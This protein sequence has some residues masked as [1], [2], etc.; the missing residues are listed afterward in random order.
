MLTPRGLSNPL[1]FVVGTLPEGNEPEE[2]N[3]DLPTYLGWVMP[4]DEPLGQQFWAHHNSAA[5]YAIA[6]GGSL[7]VVTANAATCIVYLLCEW[8]D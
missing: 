2:W 7:R 1:R 4:L 5:N 6:K 3:F 8:T